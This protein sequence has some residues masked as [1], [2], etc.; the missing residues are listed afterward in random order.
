M[1][2]MGVMSVF[3][4]ITLTNIQQHQTDA[5]IEQLKIMHKKERKI[6]EDSLKSKGEALAVNLAQNLYE[7]IINFDY[8]TVDAMAK[9]VQADQSV[10]FVNIKGINGGSIFHGGNDTAGDLKIMHQVGRDGD[11]IATLEIILNPNQ[12]NDKLKQMSQEINTIIADNIH[13]SGDNIHKIIIITILTALIGV[14]FICGFIY[15]IFTITINQPLQALRDSA[16]SISKGDL[17]TTI[18]VTS[19]NEIGQ[20]AI[21]LN[22]MIES[23]R[24]EKRLEKEIEERKRIEKELITA[25]KSAEEYGK[26][27]LAAAKAKSDFLANMSHEIRTPMNGVIGMAELLMETE[28][29]DEQAEFVK[30]ICESGDSL[31]SIINDILDF[32][33]IESGNLELEEVPL[34]V[35]GLIETTFDMFRSKAQE[36]ELELIYYIEPDVPPY[37]RGDPVRIKQ[38]LINLVGN[39]IKFTEKGEVFVSVRQVKQVGE[40]GEFEFSVKDSGIGINEAQQ[41]KLFQ[42]F[43]QADVSTTR[44]YGGTGL[45]LA[46]S[47]RIVDIMGGKIWLKSKEGEGAEFLFTLKLN[48][49]ENSLVETHFGSNI[50]EL[51]DKDVLIVDDNATNLKILDLQCRKWGMKTTVVDTPGKALDILNGGRIFNIGLIDMD[52]PEMNGLE[53]GHKI[54]AI[55]N[56]EEMPLLL[57]SSIQK[58]AATDI[59]GAVFY[60]Y[61]SKPIKQA[62][63]FSALVQAVSDAEYRQHARMKKIQKEEILPSDLSIEIPLNILIAEDNLINIRLAENVFSKMGYRIDVAKTGKE[64]VEMALKNRYDII[65]MDCQMPEMN[66]YD[67]TAEIRSAGLKTIIIAMTANAFEE[68]KKRCLD[69]G[70]ND[71]LS[72]PMRKRELLAQLRKWGK[73]I[74]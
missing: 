12:I 45:G 28:L 9:R 41:K 1:I 14:L 23:L 51:E 34:Q 47:Q 36:K 72:K 52:L 22:E 56:K 10:L 43:S 60:K 53:L 26:A 59:P 20:L 31:L 4:I 69:V 54:R 17:N 67:A 38:I 33:K 42:P 49:A 58:P 25:K 39:A 18:T 5:F 29:D 21:S 11:I 65:F 6:F 37:L 40:L 63:L 48:I 74:H 27:A 50:V 32:S 8:E 19:N 24:N 70:M 30:I 46:I 62:Q 16:E 61:L 15:W 55:Y 68:D 13:E 64:A 35:L 73:S 3:F 7:N 2:L 66:G 57:L 71:Y 44:K